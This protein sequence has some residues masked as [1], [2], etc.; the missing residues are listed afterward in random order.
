MNHKRLK[1]NLVDPILQQKLMKTLAPP[2]EDYWAPTKNIFQI[3]YQDYIKPNIWLIILVIILLLLL[4]YRYRT[5][6]NSRYK[7]NDKSSINNLNTSYTTNQTVV[8]PINQKKQRN[9]SINE[10]AELVMSAYTQ[11]KEDL[12]E[13]PIIK[14]NR[15]FQSN[16]K[17]SSFAYP[18]YPYIKGG[19]LVSSGQR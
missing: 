1:P 10:Y 5:I 6:Q 19:S 4:L 8:E 12:R 15:Q 7:E 11:Q 17:N 18:M 16:K 13:P 9:N 2:K 3:A 14:N